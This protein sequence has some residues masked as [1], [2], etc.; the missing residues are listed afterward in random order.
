MFLLFWHIHISFCLFALENCCFF[1]FLQLGSLLLVCTTW[2]QSNTN[3]AKENYNFQNFN[4]CFSF[5]QY[6]H[7]Y[8]KKKALQ[9]F[10]VANECDNESKNDFSYQKRMVTK[11]MCDT[12]K[13]MTKWVWL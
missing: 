12:N 5:P 4:I 7:I 9:I 1:F 10:C 11:K 6:N 8:K 3:I 2:T 13:Q